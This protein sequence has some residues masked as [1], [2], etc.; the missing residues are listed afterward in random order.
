MWAQ[1]K[2]YEQC[3]SALR[4]K[5]HVQDIANLAKY[6][7]TKWGRSSEGAWLAGAERLAN[8]TGARP[9][10]A[11]HSHECLVVCRPPGRS[12]VAI[13]RTVSWRSSTSRACQTAW[14]VAIG[15]WSMYP[16]DSTAV[17]TVNAITGTSADTMFS[18]DAPVLSAA[19]FSGNIAYLRGVPGTS[20]RPY[21]SKTNVPVTGSLY[22]DL[23]GSSFGAADATASLAIYIFGQTCSTNTWTSMTTA[24][25]IRLKGLAGHC[26]NCINFDY[27]DHGYV[28]HKYKGLDAL[29]GHCPPSLIAPEP[30]RI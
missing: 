22:L 15:K 4:F 10:A 21:T 27:T 8:G 13:W 16:W 1:N 25:C 30:N 7:A 3:D 9:A 19:A 20:Y 12:G 29:A 18:F 28:N 24:R 23:R 2:P 26:H 14:P 17:I 6:A 5:I 11:R